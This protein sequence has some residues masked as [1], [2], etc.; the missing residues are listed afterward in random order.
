ME[1]PGV[2]KITHSY[3][4]DSY[5]NISVDAFSNA[6]RDHHSVPWKKV[7]RKEIAVKKVGINR[8]ATLCI[9]NLAY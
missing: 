3:H 7:S 8:I 4:E 5:N 1:I 9:E 2:F 6:M